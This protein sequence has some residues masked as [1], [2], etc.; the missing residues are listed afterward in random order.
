MEKNINIIVNG[1]RIAATLHDAGGKS[2]VIF[3]HGYRG[4]ST[5]PS[6][7]FVTAAR[8]LSDDGISSLRIDQ[9]GSGNSDGDFKDSSFQDWIETTQYLAKKY[10]EDG[11]IVGL[12]GQSMGAATVIA[13]ASRVEKISAV[14]AWVPDPSVDKFTPPKNGFIEE[15]GQMVQAKYWQ[16]AHDE[17]VAEKLRNVVA[18]C[19]IVQ[20]SN[21]EYVSPENH[22]AIVDNAGPHHVVEMFEN[23]THS[24]WSYSQAQEIVRRSCVFLQKNLI[25]KNNP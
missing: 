21:D 17:R 7:L 13:A 22:K 24:S 4:D 11:Y 10:I 9:F 15:G 16:E 1:H 18:P 23:Y 14:V 20:A 8:R 12:F 19:Y 6:R 3:C 25:S 2:I 5:G